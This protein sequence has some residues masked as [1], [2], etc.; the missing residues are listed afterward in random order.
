MPLCSAGRFTRYRRI[1]SR[2]KSRKNFIKLDS[3]TWAQRRS[4]GPKQLHTW[5]F[6]FAEP[7]KF[8]PPNAEQP[9]DRIKSQNFNIKTDKMEHCPVDQVTV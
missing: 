3:F 4:A 6:L 2:A 7:S 5:V 8:C 9:Q 1:D